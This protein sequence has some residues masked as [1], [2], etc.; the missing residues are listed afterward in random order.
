MG[1]DSSKQKKIE[2]PINTNKNLYIDKGQNEEYDARI[3][4]DT[5]Y[6]ILTGKSWPVEI[7]NWTEYQD[8]SQRNTSQIAVLGYEKMGKSFLLSKI[9]DRTLPQGKHTKTT[10]VCVLYPKDKQHPWTALDTPGTNVSVKAEEV[11]KDLE[12]YF[13]NK[14]ITKDEIMRMLYG[15]NILMEALLQ[16]F[17]VHHSQVILIVINKLRRD[18]QRLI[19]R[20][21][22]LPKKRV[23][24]VHN[25]HESHDIKN[26]Q[27][28]I[29]DDVKGAFNVKERVIQSSN[30]VRNNIVYLEDDEKATEHLI[31]AHEGSPAGKYY[32]EAA[33]SYIR[34]VIDGCNHA[35]SFDLVNA[36]TKHL[37]TYIRK[38][39][40]CN[41]GEVINEDQFRLI[42][43]D[44]RIPTGIKLT[45][46]K[47]YDLKLS[48]A[49][50][51]GNIQTYTREGLEEVP[52]SVKKF[53]RETDTGALQ[54]ILII[55]FEVAGSC[56]EN[57]L[58]FK[59]DEAGGNVKII[60][61]GVSH[62]NAK[63]DNTDVIIKNT[64]KFG[65]F[66]IVTEIIPIM[67]FT[68]NKSEKAQITQRVPGLVTVV[69]V[70]HELGTNVA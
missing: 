53:I 66:T 63:R 49:N 50:E 4:S 13:R 43:D 37:N 52:F 9:M 14:G 39:L 57:E 46:A 22:T 67:G 60:I 8:Y 11:K 45:N 41:G 1:C 28:I 24:I 20:I 30:S 23:L 18:D 38:Y 56:D 51:F 29:R 21:Q 58:Q 3:L 26:V 12:T 35:H 33:I 65:S 2:L 36:F 64:R 59:V 27:D 61:N 32:N 6:S 68:I 54:N 31:L 19:S 25:L 62:D 40:A 55:E 69:F 34:H 5:F 48:T 7:K 42:K 44:A 16:E 15:D 10:G 70:L 47:S 17:V